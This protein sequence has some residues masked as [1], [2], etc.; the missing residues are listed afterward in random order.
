[1]LLF[2]HIQMSFFCKEFWSQNVIV[3]LSQ[4]ADPVYFFQNG[5]CAV[6]RNCG[7]GLGYC[8]SRFERR[9]PRKSP[10][11]LVATVKFFSIFLLLLG[12]VDM[13]N[14]RSSLSYGGLWGIIIEWMETVMGVPL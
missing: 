11:L 2:I 7:V 12:S 10:F 4:K 6:D 13:A 1:M 3:L 5:T 14:R 8:D 9:R